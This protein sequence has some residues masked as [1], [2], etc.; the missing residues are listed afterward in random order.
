MAHGRTPSM[1]DFLCSQ[2]RHSCHWLDDYVWLYDY[3]WLD[4]YTQL[5]DYT[6]LYDYTSLCGYTWPYIANMA[7]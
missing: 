3:T 7:I 2:I 5:Y 6:W 1:A 4:D